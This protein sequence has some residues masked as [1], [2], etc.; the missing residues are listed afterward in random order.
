MTFM[1]YQA[2]IHVQDL[3]ALYAQIVLRIVNGQ[4]S[5]PSGEV[6]Y[7]FAFAHRVRWW[8]ALDVIA[9]RMYARGLVDT[10]QVETWSS[11]DEAADQL[12]FPR[13]HCRAMGTSR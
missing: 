4:E 9:Q 2:A 13:A 12:G 3:V 5:V 6:A 7:Y 11:Y 1:Q 8:A 10:P